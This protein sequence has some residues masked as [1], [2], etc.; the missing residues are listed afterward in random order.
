MV[1]YYFAHPEADWETLG[2]LVGI[3]KEAAQRRFKKPGVLRLLDK[4]ETDLYE[5]ALGI[6]EIALRNSYKYIKNPDSIQGFEMTKMFVKALADTPLSM[7]SAP[8]DMPT[9]HEPEEEPE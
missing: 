4:I 5:Q 2:K 9:F 6:R 7:P 3:G 1:R 8:Q